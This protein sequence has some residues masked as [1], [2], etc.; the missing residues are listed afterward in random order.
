VRDGSVKV[1]RDLE[2]RT[3]AYDVGDGPGERAIEPPTPSSAI[4]MA[5]EK[6]R[7]GTLSAPRHTTVPLSPAERDR[8]RALGYIR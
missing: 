8:L 6:F 5:L 1:V 7:A 3:F 2:G 4:M